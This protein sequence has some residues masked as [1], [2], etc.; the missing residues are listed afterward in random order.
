ME[1]SRRPGELVFSVVLLAFA[2]AAFWQAYGISGFKGLS[3]PGVFPMLATGAMVLASLINVVN[4]GRAPAPS[5]QTGSVQAR[6]LREYIP[7]RHLIV[8]AMLAI[9]VITMPWL[10]FVVGS[11]IFLVAMIQFLWRKNLLFTLAI[12]VIALALVYFVFRTLFQV[13]LPQGSLF[14]GLY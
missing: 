8:F 14:P 3:T 9:Y 13:V 7:A 4:Q 1:L 5:T 6:F 11:G 10:G 2:L 12:S